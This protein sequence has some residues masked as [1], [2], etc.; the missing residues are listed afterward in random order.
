MTGDEEEQ[1]AR[2]AM[3]QKVGAALYGDAFRDGRPGWVHPLGDALGVSRRAMERWARGDGHVP[4]LRA[5]L[6][7]LCLARGEALLELAKAL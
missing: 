5:E 7:H 3:L 4:D 2:L 1:A 6:R